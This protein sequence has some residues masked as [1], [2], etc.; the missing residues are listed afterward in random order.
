M[1]QAASWDDL[2]RRDSGGSFQNKE[3]TI[4][5]KNLSE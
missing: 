4:M 1:N 3:T 2:R 5:I